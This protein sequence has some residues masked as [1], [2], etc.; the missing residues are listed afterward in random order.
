MTIYFENEHTISFLSDDERKA[1]NS[2]II[3]SVTNWK[4]EDIDLINGRYCGSVRY[5]DMTFAVETESLVFDGEEF[6]DIAE[7][8][9]ITA[10]RVR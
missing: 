1:L 7:D 3:D 2:R 6:S 10:K 9:E 4:G 5:K 8:A